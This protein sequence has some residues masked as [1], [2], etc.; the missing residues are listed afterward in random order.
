MEASIPRSLRSSQI[1]GDRQIYA[2]DL[3][4]FV[5]AISVMFYH[6]AFIIWAT[7]QVNVSYHLLGAYAWPGWIGVEVFF[8]LSGFIISF[9]AQNATAGAFAKSRF[10]R[11]YPTAWVGSTFTAIMLLLGHI[12][13]FSLKFISVWLNTNLLVTSGPYLDGSYWTLQVEL[14]FYL[15]IFLL[16]FFS[17]FRHAITVMS[18]IGLISTACLALYAAAHHGLIRPQGTFRRVI[19]SFVDTPISRIF[20]VEDGCFFAIGTLLWACLLRRAT[21]WRVLLLLIC[22]AGAILEIRIHARNLSNFLHLDYSWL[23]PFSL[24]LASLVSIIFAIK[25][26][27]Q[28]GSWL[29]SRGVAFARVLGLMTYP[30]YLIHQ[31]AGYVLVSFLHRFIPDLGALFVTMALFILL[32][33]VIHSYL[34]R[35]I[36]RHLRNLLPG[37]G[38]PLAEPATTLP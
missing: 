3:I 11:L 8:M 5:A 34:E 33:F 21:P 23:P 32:S 9:S 29:G 4:R 22:C 13:A 25:F 38:K 7:R 10:I 6:L 24:W 12:S 17:H 30:L 28:I 2:L 14:S 27:S 37:G 15:I 35:P 20:L 18:C 26:N 36:Q 16:L 1:S 31:R 19:F